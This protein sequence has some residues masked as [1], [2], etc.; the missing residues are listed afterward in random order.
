MELLLQILWKNYVVAFYILG[1]ALILVLKHVS[2]RATYHVSYF[3]IYLR[4]VLPIMVLKNIDFCR[5][6]RD[7]AVSHTMND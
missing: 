1:H 2:G 5:P 6:R 4:L 7:Q 3:K